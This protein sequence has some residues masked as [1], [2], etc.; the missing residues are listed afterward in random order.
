MVHILLI[1]GLVTHKSREST[2]SQPFLFIFHILQSV[3]FELGTD[4]RRSVVYT[5]LIVGVFRQAIKKLMSTVVFGLLFDFDL[6]I[7]LHNCSYCILGHFWMF[8]EQVT[9]FRL[10]IQSCNLT[11]FSF[12]IFLFNLRLLFYDSSNSTTLLAT[13]SCF[14]RL[15]QRWR[16]RP[17]SD[18]RTNF[19]PKL[20]IQV[21]GNIR[22]NLLFQ[23]FFH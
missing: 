8:H 5:R 16:I 23:F 2:L 22:S 17:I 13:F 20:L 9:I 15:T 6:L 7:L 4:V 21:L 19:N 1:P 3:D 11:S 18:P 12:A 10:N 14:G